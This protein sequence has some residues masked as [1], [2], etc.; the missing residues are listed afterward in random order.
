MVAGQKAEW[1]DWYCTVELSDFT[2]GGA[3]EREREREREWLSLSAQ[4]FWTWDTWICGLGMEGVDCDPGRRINVHQGFLFFGHFSYN[5]N[6]HVIRECLTSRG[7]LCC[8]LRTTISDI[9]LVAVV[10]LIRRHHRSGQ[11]D[12]GSLGKVWA[13]ISVFLSCSL[14]FCFP[15]VFF[16]TLRP[17][18]FYIPNVSPY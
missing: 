11:F 7:L 2:L 6:I 1:R 14:R 18:L 13:S 16:S 12:W 8:E 9:C 5:S 17:I 3:E 4:E 10:G 15:R